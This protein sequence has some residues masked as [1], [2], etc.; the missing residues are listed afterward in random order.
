MCA[1]ISVSKDAV[2][3]EASLLGKCGWTS[4]LN[5]NFK[6]I[7]S[8]VDLTVIVNFDPGKAF[9]PLQVPVHLKN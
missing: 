5:S 9:Q 4:K 6:K 7:T 1:S 2:K 3:N 8:R